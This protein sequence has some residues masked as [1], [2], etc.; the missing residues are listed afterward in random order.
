MSA[1]TSLAEV[2][3][4]TIQDLIKILPL[5]IQEVES[6]QIFSSLEDGDHFRGSGDVLKVIK[7]P[8]FRGGKPSYGKNRIQ[9]FRITANIQCHQ[10]QEIIPLIWFN[11]YPGVIKKIEA[12]KDLYFLGQIKSNRGIKQIANPQIVDPNKVNFNESDKITEYPTINKVPGKSIKKLIDAIPR[13]LWDIFPESLPEEI[14]SKRE[15][16]NE[17]QSYQILHGLDPKQD[18]ESIESAR[19]RLIYQEFFEDQLKFQARRQ[20]NQI[21]KISPIETDLSDLQKFI[22]LFPYD[23]TEDQ[24]KTLFQIQEDFK[25]N[26]PMMRMV[27]GDVGCGKTTI[28]LVAAFLIINKGFQV[29][30]MAPTEALAQQHYESSMELCE[31][32]KIK[33]SLLVGNTKTKERRVILD[34]LKNGI[35]NFAI[36]TH[37]LFQDTVEFKNL[38]LCI[39]DE[40]H[41]FGVDQRLRLSKKGDHPHNLIMSATPI[42]RSLSLAQYGDLE[43]SIVATMPGGR[44]GVKTRIVKK[45]TYSQFLSFMK[46]RLSLNEQAYV[47][48]PAIED[49]PEMDLQNVEEVLRNYQIAFP[50][51]TTAALHGKLKADEKEDVLTRFISGEINILISTSV[52]EVG[53]NNPNATIMAI[54]DPDR[55]GLSSLHQLRGRVGR[56]Q[57]PGFCFLVTNKKIG[58]D[59]LSRIKVIEKTTDGFIIAQKD[60]EIRGDGDIFGSNQSGNF[61]QRRLSN[62]IIHASILEKVCLYM[63]DFQIN[64]PHIVNSLIEKYSLDDKIS[65]TI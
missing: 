11:A 15:L 64:Q 12:S 33:S 39:V 43:I 7:Q 5:R 30:L 48:T 27:Q 20:K 35:I 38:K 65:K 21:I 28:A 59:S 13:D 46:T 58:K 61:A 32:L 34:E 42:P 17:A 47:V 50:E 14:L 16:L 52:V 62:I 25:R 36:G 18:K 3:I 44:K 45:E 55:F 49:N 37:T 6:N 41:K 26:Y 54:Y 29:A 51:Y 4:K 10:T 19:Q 2:G 56:G 31:K 8:Q 23:L 57:K 60:L 22:S 9:L 63:S 53:I 24:R 1:T 40:Q